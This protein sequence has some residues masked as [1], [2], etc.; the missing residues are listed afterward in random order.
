MAISATSAPD[1]HAFSTLSTFRTEM[2]EWS[3][4]WSTMLSWGPLRWMSQ[5]CYR[6]YVLLVAM[7]MFYI[8]LNG[9]SLNGWSPFWAGRSMGDIC[10]SI[11][12]VDSH[13]WMSSDQNM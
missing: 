1:G 4:T 13:H 5:A 6:T 12:K 10:S 7:P 8:Y 11:T 3:Y 9:P 2:E